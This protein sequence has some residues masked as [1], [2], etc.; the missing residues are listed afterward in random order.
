[1]TQLNI[2]CDSNMNP[3]DLLSNLAKAAIVKNTIREGN[4]GL[5]KR[6]MKAGGKLE[7]NP[8]NCLREARLLFF[9]YNYLKYLKI[10]Y[11]VS[12]EVRK[13]QYVSIW[14]ES[15]ALLK[16][17]NESVSVTT[18]F[19][20]VEILILL[21]NKFNA[22]VVDD[23]RKGLL[24]DLAT[25]VNK[26]F[27][28]EVTFIAQ[29]AALKT[30][31]GFKDQLNSG[32]TL[33]SPMPPTIYEY[34]HNNRH[35]KLVYND[36][37]LLIVSEIMRTQFHDEKDLQQKYRFQSFKVLTQVMASTFMSMA[38]ANKSDK[39]MVRIRSVLDNMFP[40]LQ[41]RRRDNIYF[42]ECASE[43]VHECMVKNTNKFIARELQ[44]DIMAVFDMGPFFRCT[45]NTLKYWAKIIDVTIT[46]SKTDLLDE[47]LRK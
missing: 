24:E 42:V 13:G 31:V 2:I 14:A 10:D 7:G 40:I 29:F 16:N 5:R 32:F 43:V 38:N 39:L 8:V 34:H 3:I 11:N 27:T 21:A 23:K 28:D 6:A 25:D 33:I 18:S 41:D 1:M 20:M 26:V 47:Y 35:F 15:L 17:F 36:Q 37:K 4:S 19:W 44:K 9:V 12:P 46:L 22:T 45:S 30:C